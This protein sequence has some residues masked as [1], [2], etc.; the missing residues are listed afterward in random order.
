MIDM[1]EN[2]KLVV[3]NI[4]WL[5]ILFLIIKFFIKNKA[6]KDWIATIGI[7]LIT[8]SL[9][10]QSDILIGIYIGALAIAIIFISFNEEHYK[11]LFYTGIVITI[12]NIVVQLWEFWSKLPVYLY[13]LLVGAALITFVTYKEINKKNHPEKYQ[14]KPVS[15]PQINNQQFNINQPVNNYPQENNVVED[16]FQIV[17]DNPMEEQT[18]QTTDNSIRF[19][20]ACGKKNNGGKFC[21]GCGRNLQR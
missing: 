1:A 17:D 16:K 19:C 13:F 6:A 18:S 11:K 4:F 14:P 12:I 7:I 3:T 2:L 20:P 15:Q 21:G 9:I 8:W 10:F 5:Y